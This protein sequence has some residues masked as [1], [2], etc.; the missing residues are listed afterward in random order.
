MGIL[1]HITHQVRA[2][3][4]KAEYKLGDFDK[5]SREKWNSSEEK[6]IE[7]M[8]QLLQNSDPLNVDE[9]LL[10]SSIEYLSEFGLYDEREEGVNKDLRWYSGIL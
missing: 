9:S 8:Y 1:G 7:S 10:G 2:L 5:R 3:D 6:G 4:E